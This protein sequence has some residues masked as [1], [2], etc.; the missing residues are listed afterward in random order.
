M[1][2]LRAG[3]QHTATASWL[4][5]VMQAAMSWG[6]VL[7]L[8][9]CCSGLFPH[10]RHLVVDRD[11]AEEVFSGSGPSG[12]RSM[13]LSHLGEGFHAAVDVLV[14]VHGRDLH[15]DARLALGHHGVAEANHVNAWGGSAGRVRAGWDGG[16][17]RC[18]G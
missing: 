3:C 7:L 8:A 1:T 13:L 16:R 5:H 10:Q 6:T 11:S 17:L 15:P 14:T 2:L 18:T 9:A 4:T 12:Q